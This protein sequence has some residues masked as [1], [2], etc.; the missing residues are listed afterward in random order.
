VKATENELESGKF[1][2]QI[3][4]M[5]KRLR[6]FVL[7]GIVPKVMKKSLKIKDFFGEGEIDA[8]SY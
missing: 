8:L 6:L 7:S 4:C 3:D 2:L 5:T 1:W